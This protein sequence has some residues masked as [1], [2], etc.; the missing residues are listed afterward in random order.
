MGI[1]TTKMLLALMK[2]IKIKGKIVNEKLRSTLSFLRFVAILTMRE[3]YA[4]AQVVKLNKL[5]YENANCS[6]EI[7]L[8]NSQSHLLTGMFVTFQEPEIGKVWLDF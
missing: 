2:L 5:D 6:P 3:F 4:S 7:L 8:N 1:K